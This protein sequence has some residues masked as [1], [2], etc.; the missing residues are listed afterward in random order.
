VVGIELMR[1]RRREL[2]QVVEFRIRE[3][4]SERLETIHEVVELG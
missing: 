2:L 3:N 4:I 1:R